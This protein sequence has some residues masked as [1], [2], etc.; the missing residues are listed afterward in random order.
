M[1][2]TASVHRFGLL[3]QPSSELQKPSHLSP[4]KW[5]RD[6]AAANGGWTFIGPIVA[7]D[8]PELV[9]TPR[10]DEYVKIEQLFERLRELNVSS[11]RYEAE[12]RNHRKR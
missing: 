10:L 9:W 6:A 8:H 12:L 1:S 4:Y 5:L 2:N 11:A 7:R 3:P